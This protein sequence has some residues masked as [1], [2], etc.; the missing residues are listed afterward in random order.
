MKLS[1]TASGR[2]ISV[3]DA[4]QTPDDDVFLPNTLSNQ[5]LPANSNHLQLPVENRPGYVRRRS[6]SQ[7]DAEPSSLSDRLELSRQRD[8]RASSPTPNSEGVDSNNTPLESISSQ[9]KV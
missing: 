7:S 1:P 9:K 4:M 8:I 2:D 6:L 3:S 5:A